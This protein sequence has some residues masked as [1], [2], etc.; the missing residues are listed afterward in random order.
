MRAVLYRIRSVIRSRLL[1]TVAVTLIVAAVCGVV[2]AF[3]A[4]ARRTSTAPDRYTA[5]FGGRFD[6]KVTQGDFSSPR[7]RDVAS[8]PGVASVDPLTYIFA[9]LV[10]SD[11]NLVD[12]TAVFIGAP[13]A[14]ELR[15][16]DG[17]LT[18]P[19][20]EHEF[21]ANRSFVEQT[22][23]K[24][25]DSFDL[26][27]ITQEQAR[28]GGFSMDDPQGPRGSVVLVG[29]VG[30]AVQ[31]EDSSPLAAVSSAW[32]HESD[33]GVG[34]TLMAVDL[35]PGVDLPTL[36]AQ[37]DT[38]PSHDSFRL[39]PGVLIGDPVRNAVRAQA[40]GL[41]LL[42]A[43]AAIAAIA[44]LGQVITRQ[45]RLA[46]D[47][48]Q[49]LSAIGFTRRQVLADAVGRAVIPITIG[50]LLG[51]ALAC[52]PSGYFPFGFVRILEPNPGFHLDW[53][54]MVGGAVVFIVALTL[55][56]L[57]TLASSTWA[58]RP[59]RPSPM[60]EAVAT[61][62]TSATAA[63]GMRLA[64]TRSARE[65]GT[66][67]GSVAGVL[68]SVAGLVAAITFGV[69]LDRLVH[70]PFRYGANYDATVGDSGADTVP[71]GL[72]ERLDANPD[73]TALTLATGSEARVGDRTVPIL[74]LEAVRGEAQPAV[75]SGRLPVSEDEIALG[76]LTAHDIGVHVGD[77][78][79]MAGPTRTKVFRVT[80]IAVVP[81]L[82]SNDGIGEGGIVTMGGLSR[83]DDKAL[84]TSIA[85]KLRTSRE[86]FFSSLPEFANLPFEP[87]YVPSAIVNVSHIRAIPFVLAGV[88][89]ALALLTVSHGM[90]T[91]M[92]SRRRDLAI[93]RSLGADRGWITRAV[94]WQASLL[95]ALPVVVGI[96]VGIVV[97]RLVFAAFADSM[98]AVNDAAI[99]LAI[100]AIGSV[101]LVAVANAIA[102]IISRS[103]RR[104]EPAL[105][106][107]SE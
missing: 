84:V 4:G 47:E 51:A 12:N 48:H 93:L 25:G 21:V 61:R 71:E 90:V 23:A 34:D 17:R 55:W 32:F 39:E 2:I 77:D 50:S 107:Q 54:A 37:L 73:V 28:A 41:W 31:L 98:G 67:R 52:L 87:E 20:D 76:R 30:G 83:I 8:L 92:R 43:I 22:H 38:L 86:E 75:T 78:V 82:G 72:V 79:T 24:I 85:V 57:V 101:A 96:P 102:G 94:H 1:A 100:V 58:V 63:T 89:A 62:A 88:L 3:A 106:L 42:A 69:S 60:V 56:T 7:Y 33:I 80:G 53:V 99:P 19:G 68:L 105:L 44:A 74:G 45:V 26:V 36:R 40:R 95:T 14:T 49:R 104:H 11:G 46:Q 27:T 6:A 59:S 10:D 103:A 29:V 65:R 16:V 66:I 64:F 13:R 81:G 15:L 5:S 9:G 35:R 97:G 70:Q 18:D 91:S